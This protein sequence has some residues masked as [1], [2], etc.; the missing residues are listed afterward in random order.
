[1]PRRKKSS[2]NPLVIVGAVAVLALGA[3]A[4]WF[5]KKKGT[6]GF[7]GVS[8]FSLSDY[9]NNPAST[10]ANVYQLE[11]KVTKQL[12]WTDGGRLF[13]VTAKGADG[14]SEEVGVLF[15]DKF[16]KESIQVGQEFS[17]KVEVQRDTVL[18]VVDMR[19]S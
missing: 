13:S 7:E 15:P 4:L 5:F 18:K 2:V 16:A 19:R 10:R 12:R 1:M 11:A 3:G 8:R 9:L 6:D 14:D 17:L